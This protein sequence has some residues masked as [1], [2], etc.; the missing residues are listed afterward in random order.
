MFHTHSI[1]Q[2]IPTQLSSHIYSRFFSSFVDYLVALVGNEQKQR[3]DHHPLFLPLESPED[4][5][6]WLLV[7]V[8]I[9]P[10]PHFTHVSSQPLCLSVVVV[11]G[12]HQ[13]WPSSGGLP[14]RWPSR[15]G[16]L[17]AGPAGRQIKK[18]TEVKKSAQGAAQEAL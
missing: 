18:Y 5:L 10:N 6:E 11:V 12:R 1:Y 3:A 7:G 9:S 4:W 8:A 16:Q 17:T 14:R 15:Y 13:E 2:S